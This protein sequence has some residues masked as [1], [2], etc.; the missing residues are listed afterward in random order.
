MNKRRYL[1][2]LAYVKGGRMLGTFKSRKPLVNGDT[3]I[4]DHFG[5]HPEGLMTVVK[6]IELKNKQFVALCDD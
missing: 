6:V 5:T 2:H 3:V 4:Y 1:Y